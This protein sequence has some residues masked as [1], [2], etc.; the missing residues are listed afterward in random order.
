LPHTPGNINLIVA[1]AENNGIGKDNQL[2]WHLPDDFKW[3][4]K[5][6]SGNPVIMGRK[7]MESIVKPLS[8]RTNLVISRNPEMIYEGFDYCSGLKEALLKAESE[9][10]PIF[11]IGG[12]EIYRQ[13][14]H[15]ADTIF[16][17]RVFDNPEATVFFPEL[18]SKWKMTYSFFHP[19]DNRH[20]FEFEFQIWRKA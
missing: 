2:L 18:D 8:G 3:F 12:S 17:T 16:L 10:K 11:I 5:I 7:T 6:T 15:L 19:V 9:K 13:Y 4:K 1:A 20:L 14:F